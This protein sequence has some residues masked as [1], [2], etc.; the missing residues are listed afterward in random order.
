MPPH[1]RSFVHKTLH[2]NHSTL[3]CAESIDRPNIALVVAPLLNSRKPLDE[4][5]VFFDEEGG[6]KIGEGAENTSEGAGLIP[7]IVYVDDKVDCK[8]LAVAHRM[9][10]KK[11]HHRE[12]ANELI[13]PFS[14]AC[15]AKFQARTLELVRMG[16]C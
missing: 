9:R 5:G 12:M 6:E 13:R 1:I 11:P 10:L 4:L 16:S 8:L 3:L 14:R 2:L 7:T 15:S